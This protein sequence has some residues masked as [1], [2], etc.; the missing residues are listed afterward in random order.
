MSVLQLNGCIC[1]GAAE[2]AVALH[3]RHQQTQHHL[4]ELSGNNLQKAVS[5]FICTT[6]HGIAKQVKSALFMLICT[7]ITCRDRD[8]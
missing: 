3:V 1:A 7:V 8:P 5:C 4:P 2:V 6:N